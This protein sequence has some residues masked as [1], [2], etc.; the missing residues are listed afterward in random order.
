LL[1]TLDIRHL[2]IVDAKGALVGMLSDRDLRT[3]SDPYVVMDEYVGNLQSV[4]DTNVA[5]LM[6]TNVFSVKPDSDA[7]EIVKL[8]LEHKIGAVPVVEP[9][10][11]LVGIVSYVDLIRLLLLDSVNG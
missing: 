7:S 3:L 8:M 6:S 9:G 2:P 5:T 11:M 1:R 10:G 4:L